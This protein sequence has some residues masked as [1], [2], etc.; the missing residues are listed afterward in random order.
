MATTDTNDSPTQA[1]Y[2]QRVSDACLWSCFSRTR[3]EGLMRDGHVRA[4]RRTLVLTDSLRAHI[5]SL[6]SAR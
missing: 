6:P 3:L 4:G 5:G 2:S 1:P